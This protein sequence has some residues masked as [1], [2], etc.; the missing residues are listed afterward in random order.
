[1]DIAEI[2]E[3]YDQ[4]L[5]LWAE[6]EPYFDWARENWVTIA[7]SAEIVGAVV[8]IMFRRYRLGFGWMIAAL[9]TIWVGAR[10]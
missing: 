5:K 9:G 3:L 2:Q 7:L 6:V 8:A 4:L 10:P 1:M